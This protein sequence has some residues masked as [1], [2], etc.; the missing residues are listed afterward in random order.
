MSAETIH[1]YASS[2]QMLQDVKTA[3]GCTTPSA[4]P[5]KHEQSVLSKPLSLLPKAPF[6][7]NARDKALSDIHA[8]LTMSKAAQQKPQ[9][10]DSDPMLSGEIDDA[11]LVQACNAIETET[12]RGGT[13]DII[14][15]NGTNDDPDGDEKNNI[16][17]GDGEEYGD[18][19]GDTGTEDECFD[20]LLNNSDNDE[21]HESDNITI[22]EASELLDADQTME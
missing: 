4:I 13:N 8:N 7:N 16:E 18:S 3:T 14:H 17:L 2:K 15:S 22:D 19:E 9:N 10:D 6:V 20:E 5:V 21:G 12:L 1:S 11:T